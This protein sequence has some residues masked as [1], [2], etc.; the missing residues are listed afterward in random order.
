[1][2]IK[3]PVTFDK[4]PGCE[5]EERLFEKLVTQLK[6][7]GL[8]KKEDLTEGVAHQVPLFDPNKPSPILLAG[9]QQT[10]RVLFIYFDVCAECGTMY[11]TKFEVKEAKAMAQQMPGQ[12]QM[13]HQKFPFPQHG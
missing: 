3:K 5:S 4:C 8:I 10:V 6:K 11:C 2:D 9:L 13:P 1:M 12:Q 7:D